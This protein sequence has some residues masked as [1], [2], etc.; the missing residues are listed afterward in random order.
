[1]HKEM[2]EGL[3]MLWMQPGSISG[4]HPGPGSC[5]PSALDASSTFGHAGI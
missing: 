3:V 2:I 4:V 1:M 5:M